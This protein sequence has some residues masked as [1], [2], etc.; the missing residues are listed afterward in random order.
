MTTEVLRSRDWAGTLHDEW[1]AL[2]V[3]S[4]LS[5]IFQ[6]WEWQSTWWKYFGGV[7]KPHLILLR[8]GR[9][10]VGIMPMYETHTAWR[11]LRPIGFK[12]SDY[13]NP[14]ARRG[15]EDFCAHAWCDYFSGLRNIDVIDLHQVKE[16]QPILKHLP[17][18]HQRHHSVTHLLDLP[19]TFE[20]LLATLSKSLRYEAKRLDREPFKSGEA[21]IETVRDPAA[22]PAAYGALLDLHLR[23][24]EGRGLSP[25]F[26][27]KKVQAFHMEFGL[28]A[29]R[30]DRLRLSLL[31]YGGETVGALYAAKLNDTIYFIQSGFD[32]RFKNLSPG[33]TLLAH[34]LREGIADGAKHLDL[35]RGAQAYKLRWQPQHKLESIR[36]SLPLNSRRGSW[37]HKWNYESKDM[38]RDFKASLKKLRPRKG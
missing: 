1:E 29:C 23:R 22:I 11:T 5:T 7:R 25:Q 24:W 16:D 12:Q 9:D 8:E 26:V 15:Y 4:P 28:L 13:L 36:V 3:D 17:G 38:L 14:I 35:L 20:A 18:S 37:G 31:R 10:L 6:T 27:S 21:T 19:D 2:I 32:P 30:R 34:T 33:T